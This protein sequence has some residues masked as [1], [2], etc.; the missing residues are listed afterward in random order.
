MKRVTAG[1]IVKKGKMLI[2]RRTGNNSL[3]GKWEFPGGKIESGETPQACL[4][5]EIDEELGLNIKVGNF[6]AAET[7]SNEKEQIH[8]MVYWAAWQAG[9]VVLRV[10]DRAEWVG[11]DELEGYDFAPADLFAVRKLLK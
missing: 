4:T 7:Y 8:L 11:L 5:R 10:H 6:F 3:S 2:A 9:D 1:I